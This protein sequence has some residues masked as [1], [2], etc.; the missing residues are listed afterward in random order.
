MARNATQ[1]LG[2]PL[3][4][5]GE[6]PIVDFVLED[7]T[8]ITLV[9]E[10]MVGLKH[11]LVFGMIFGFLFIRNFNLAIRMVV[12]RPGIMS[13]WLCLVPCLTGITWSVFITSANLY[14]NGPP[15]RMAAWC[16]ALG[17]TI[18]TVC[19]S[20]IMLQKAYLVTL[21]QRWVVVA[22]IFFILPQLSIIF[23][24]ITLCPITVEAKA[25]C[26]FSYPTFV[27]WLWLVI[28]TPINSFFSAIF[29]YVTYKQYCAFGSDAWR[30]LTKDGVKTMCLAILC[31]ITCGT[32]VIIS[33]SGDFSEMFFFI[34]WLLISL[35][36]T[37]HC[38]SMR[39]TTDLS[40]RPKTS[41][42]L[43]IS[44]IETLK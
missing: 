41:H 6:M 37:N 26:A 33:A 28:S 40:C 16:A 2:V 42:V 3:H 43:C 1:F 12:S 9:R 25:G 21:R 34:D 18:S 39:N 24:V 35:L 20:S 4:P 38:Y 19:N 23:I 29:C 30:K 14:S 27:P 36:L 5:L 11:Q 15:C 31:N 32:V 17:V 13:G 44:S 10:R 7:P 22:G 8:N